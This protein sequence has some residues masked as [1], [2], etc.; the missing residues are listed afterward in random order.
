MTKRVGWSSLEISRPIFGYAAEVMLKSVMG[1]SMKVSTPR[2]RT[3]Q[4]GLLSKRQAK[5]N[6]AANSSEN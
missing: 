1:S 4:R 3:H 5:D 6:L 2:L